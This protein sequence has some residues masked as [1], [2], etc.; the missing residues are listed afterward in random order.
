MH[1]QVNCIV[2]PVGLF[3]W[4]PSKAFCFPRASFHL[5]IMRVQN[6]YATSISYEESC[7]YEEEAAFVFMN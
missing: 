2:V 4:M 5:R 7:N 6:R 3:V 1:V